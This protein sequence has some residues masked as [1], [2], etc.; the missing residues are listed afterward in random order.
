[1]DK[2]AS[3]RTEAV[4]G[5]ASAAQ[6]EETMNQAAEHV[7]DVERALL[8]D[9]R[10]LQAEFDNY[11]NR[12]VREQTAMTTR[13]SANLVSKLLPVLD[14]LERAI[15]H[16]EGGPGMELLLKEFKQVLQQEGLEEIAAE[17]EVFDPR[18][19]EAFQ[20]VEDPDAS[21]PTVR[22]VYR[23]GYRMND[24]VVRPPMVVVAQPRRDELDEA[25]ME[26]ADDRAHSGAED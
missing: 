14:N 8:D 12:V 15:E 19:H 4:E 11:R 13:A 10:R 21:E 16:G 25:G 17:G 26:Q 1:M 7:Q 22:T 5:T 20:V 9:L 6:D 24:S 2:R 23:R 18:I 3:A